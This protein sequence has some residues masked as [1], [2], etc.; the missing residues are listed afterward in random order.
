MNKLMV[1]NSLHDIFGET[2]DVQKNERDSTFKYGPNC[3]DAILGTDQI[4]RIVHGIE[5]TDVDEIIDAYHRVHTT[6]I[7]F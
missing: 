1:D 4:L 2:C 5:L 7:D 3:T 6:D